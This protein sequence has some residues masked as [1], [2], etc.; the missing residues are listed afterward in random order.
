VVCLGYP[1]LLVADSDIRD[2]WGDDILK[3][4]PVDAAQRQIQSWHKFQ[5]TVYDSIELLTRLN[6][7]VTVLDKIPHRGNEVQV[8]LNGPLPWD[9]VGVAD[10]VIDTGTLEHCFNVG[11]A[12]RNMCELVAMDG[13]VMTAAPA[14]KLGHGYYNFCNNLYH[15]GFRV[16]GFEVVS[17]KLLDSRLRDIPIPTKKEGPPPRSI[18]MCVAQRRKIQAWQWPVQGAYV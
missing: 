2:L 4:L 9:L 16:N 13:V 5:G 1:D 17:L 8:D 10:L 15:D 11:T 7:R 12:F 18:W 6:F 3:D 14:N